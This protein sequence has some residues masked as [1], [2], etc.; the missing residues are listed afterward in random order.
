MKCGSTRPRLP[1]RQR[2][3]AELKVQGSMVGQCRRGVGVGLCL[4]GKSAAGNALYDQAASREERARAVAAVQPVMVEYKAG[5]AEL[6]AGGKPLDD[7]EI[8]SAY[9]WNMTPGSRSFGAAR[10][11]EPQLCH[12]GNVFGPG[13]A[14]ADFTS[15]IGGRSC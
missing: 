5:V 13:G 10:D 3:D 9:E 12:A 6:A 4:A 1:L 11:S 14:C 8:A 15:I 7:P 2:L